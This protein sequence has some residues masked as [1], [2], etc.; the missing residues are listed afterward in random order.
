[1]TNRVRVENG[2][3]NINSVFEALDETNYTNGII[4]T[5]SSR[6]D[7]L[8]AMG[9]IIELPDN[10]EIEIYNSVSCERT[11]KSIVEIQLVDNNK[12]E[13]IGVNPYFKFEYPS[14]LHISKFRD[15]FKHKLQEFLLVNKYK[16]F[17]A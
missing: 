13:L 4:R 7:Y 6:Y 15:D 12:K 14:E 8:Y 11:I 9:C 3:I 17:V 10:R 16:I 2:E 1:M 5:G